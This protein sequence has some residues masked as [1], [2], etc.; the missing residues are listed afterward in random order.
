[1]PIVKSVS[2]AVSQLLQSSGCGCGISIV[3]VRCIG[4]SPRQVAS[5][6]SF[7]S[8]SFSESDHPRVLITG[9][10]SYN[11]CIPA[12]ASQ[13]S[14]PLPSSLPGEQNTGSKNTEYLLELWWSFPYGDKIRVPCELSYYFYSRNLL[15]PTH[16]IFLEKNI[17]AFWLTEK[18]SSFWCDTYNNGSLYFDIAFALIFVSCVAF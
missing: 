18:N 17:K 1:M 15:K 9:Q 7:H 12:P 4:V 16:W 8:V 2:R 3:P 14:P 13:L 10:H 6:A 5:D 11:N